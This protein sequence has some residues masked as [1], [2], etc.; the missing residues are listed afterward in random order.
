MSKLSS[1]A[2][3]KAWAAKVL[4]AKED[5]QAKLKRELYA[6]LPVMRDDQRE[7]YEH[8]ARFRVLAAGR[9]YGKSVGSWREVV[10]HV[11]ANKR[12][13]YTFP[14][15]SSPGAEDT[16]HFF[17]RAFAPYRAA[18]L[19]YINHTNRLIRLHTGGYFKLIGLEATD[20]LRGPGLDFMVVDEAAFI[21][22]SVWYEILMPMLFDRGGKALIMSSTSGRN[23]FWE[24]YTRGLDPLQNDWA[25]F[26]RDSFVNPLMAGQREIIQRSNSE[27][28]VQQEYLAEFLDDAGAVFRNV[29]NCAVLPP[30][31]PQDGRRY[32]FG[33]DW[34]RDNDYTVIVVLD[35][36]ETPARVA[37]VERFNEIGYRLQRARLAALYA[38]WR[39]QNVLVESNSIG[40]TNLE[41]LQASGI[42]ARGFNTSAQS[43]PRI[44]EALALALEQETILLPAANEV[45]INE[46]LNYSMDRLPGGGFRYSA[47][48]GGH[49]DT[50]MALAIAL[51]AT[52]RGALV[53]DFA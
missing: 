10:D 33:V 4:A 50:V 29:R 8:P 20:N 36:T 5:P 25:S 16:W 49:D 28:V 44:I 17:S 19:A 38:H 14:T 37:H 2:L 48:S 47:P 21:R 34:G 35:I 22:G 23:W 51:N 43:K 26:H 15:A 46:L 42:P 3:G 13:W 7:W 32:V 12:V 18:G 11:L 52:N 6:K 40:A 1:S 39:P 30:M 31:S 9:R 24:A 27:R 45:L 41:E 53:I